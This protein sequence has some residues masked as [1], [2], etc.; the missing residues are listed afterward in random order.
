MTKFNSKFNSQTGNFEIT[1][2][3]I[4]FTYAMLSD[5]LIGYLKAIPYTER[6][7]ELYKKINDVR[8]ENGLDDIMNLND[9]MIAIA[10][11]N[12]SIKKLSATD[13]SLFLKVDIASLILQVVGYS[14][15]ALGF[16]YARYTK[17]LPQKTTIPLPPQ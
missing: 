2:N 17:Y 13:L 3:F 4:G 8:K 1:A 11:I 16:Y 10:S 7:K 6:G 9:L 14:L 12:D 5:M 15:I